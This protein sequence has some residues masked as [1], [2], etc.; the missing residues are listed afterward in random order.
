MKNK[1]QSEIK[2]LE[3]RLETIE[4]E[5][6]KASKK[7]KSLNEKRF[8]VLLKNEKTELEHY[9]IAVM[10][11]LVGLILITSFIISQNN[12]SN[13]DLIWICISAGVLGSATSALISAL[14]R[15]ANGW[16][17]SNGLKYPSDSPD[18][19][20]S[21]RMATFFMGRP[22]LGIVAGL[23][24]FFGFSIVFEKSENTFEKTSLIFWSIL[25][26]LFAKSLIA[27]LKDLFDNLIGK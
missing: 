6:K 18:D 22:L 8:E 25:A 27:K 11:I 1:D 3:S 23:I 17:F 2:S 26:G 10:I 9:F 16:E 24:V 15:K 14:Q 4:N 13:L 7:L 5:V 21:I 20:F 19:K 12:K